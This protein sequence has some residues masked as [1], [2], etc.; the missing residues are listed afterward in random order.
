LLT[1]ILY[2]L[3]VKSYLIFEAFKLINLLSIALSSLILYYIATGN[4]NLKLF[5]R[6]GTGL[7][8]LGCGLGLL[9]TI[10]FLIL[11]DYDKIQALSVIDNIINFIF[12]Y[13]LFFGSDKYI[14]MRE[15]QINYQ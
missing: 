4:K 1:L 15:E 5:I 13:Y 6:I 8:L 3:I 7:T 12:A 14:R 9:S 11:Q 2:N 10:I